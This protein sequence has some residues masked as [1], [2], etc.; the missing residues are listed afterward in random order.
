MHVQGTGGVSGTGGSL[1]NY[2][3]GCIEVLW[4]YCGGGGHSKYLQIMHFKGGGGSFG[5]GSLKTHAKHLSYYKISCFCLALLLLSSEF[6]Y[7]HKGV[8]NTMLNTM[9]T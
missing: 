5:C 9:W 1:L 8:H 7:G 2:Y 6:T 4:V 3:T